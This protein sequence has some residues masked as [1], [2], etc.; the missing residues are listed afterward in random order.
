MRPTPE[1]ETRVVID[2]QEYL[3]QTCGAEPAPSWLGSCAGCAFNTEHDT[4]LAP[5]PYV[6]MPC[7]GT[8]RA[9]RTPVI[10]VAA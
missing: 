10:W 7:M 5:L 1:H 3:A 9:D 2:G 4:C 6:D 8:H